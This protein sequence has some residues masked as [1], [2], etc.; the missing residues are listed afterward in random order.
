MEDI[1]C[2]AYQDDINKSTNNIEREPRKYVRVPKVAKCIECG[3]LFDLN[4]GGWELTHSGYLCKNC[5]K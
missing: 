4:E 1:N 3:R 2:K 5:N